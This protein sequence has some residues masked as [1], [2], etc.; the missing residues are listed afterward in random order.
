MIINFLK[1][2]AGKSLL[3]AAISLLP[4][5]GSENESATNE[6]TNTGE[7]VQT[8]SKSDDGFYNIPSPVQQVQLLQEAGATY[9]RNILNPLENS[10]K[11]TQTISKALNLGV[12]GSDL[13]YA[14]VFNQP[15]DVILYLTAS[16]KLAEALNI[17][18]DFYTDIMKRMDKSSGDRDSLLQIV[19]DVYRRS[20]E[21]L[22]ETD[23]S[24]ISALVII[25]S[26]I[27]ALY[28]GTQVAENVKNK[29]AIY[30]R[31]G[32]F[33]STLNNLVALITTAADSDFSNILT[34]LRSIK[35]IYDEASDSQ[36][37]EDQMKRLT[38]Q[39][40]AVRIKITNM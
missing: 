13:S 36:L 5:C 28:V 8:E 29:E 31:I 17:K 22:K 18:G 30:Q 16:Q 37:T 6:N 34:D 10:S 23:Q 4:S 11:Y 9:D 35:A 25:G 12:Y 15:Q 1:E 2:N 27:E 33:K 26:F 19:S 40:K 3:F 20:N 38:K 32:E 7:T 21:S 14:A 39:V 24:H